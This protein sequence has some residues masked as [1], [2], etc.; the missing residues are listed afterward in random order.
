MNYCTYYKATG[1]LHSSTGVPISNNEIDY[2][3]VSAEI[4]VDFLTFK[5]SLHHYLVVPNSTEK[6]KG[7]LV[8]KND[9][10]KSWKKV[11]D[12]LYAIPVD[13][14][15][16]LTIIQNVKDKICSIRLSPVGRVSISAINNMQ[17][18]TFAACKPK[19][20]HLPLWIWTVKITDL[21]DSDVKMSYKGQDN[22]QFYTRRILNSYS[23]EQI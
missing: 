22:L 16:E 20:P 13:I 9:L 19:D 12:V 21:F 6:H 17:Y 5:K 23:H 11:D 3:E 4:T 7:T 14:D 8:N 15:A 1:E 18:F 2:I 10:H